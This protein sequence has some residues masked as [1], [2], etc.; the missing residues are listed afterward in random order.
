MEKCKTTIK[1]IATSTKLS[2]ED[3][4]PIVDP[5]LCKKLVGS[6]LYLIATRPNIMYGLSL[7]SMFMVSPK[8][9]HWKTGK[10]I[11]R[12][13]AGT[14]YYGILFLASDNSSLIGY[15]D[16]YFASILDDWKN[17]LGYAF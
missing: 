7:I 10:R 9:F 2:K 12:Y 5:S 13:I 4:G 3:K 17:T 15:T 1:P 11:P 6:L 8:V 16:S 14:K